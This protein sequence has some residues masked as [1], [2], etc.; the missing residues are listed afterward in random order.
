MFSKGLLLILLFS[1]AVLLLGD[2]FLRLIGWER[3]CSSAYAWGVAVL[4]A[5][6]QLVA[7]PLYRLSTSFTLFFILYSA[8]LA[9][10]LF[11]AVFSAVKARDWSCYAKDFHI[12]VRG[13]REAPL[14]T[15][16]LWG[17][18]IFFL[19]FSFGFYYPTTD[20]GY[21]MTRSM[22][23]IRQ[24]SM[25]INVRFAWLGW[26][27][28]E[29][30]DYT[31][32]STFAFLISYLS[33]LSGIQATILSK[34]FFAFCLLAAHIAAILTALEAI[35]E[36]KE[37]LFEKKTFGMLFYLIFLIFSVKQDSAGN[38]MT[39]YI[40]NGK[41]FLSAFILPML[42]ASCFMLMRRAD[43]LQG[44]EWLAV[45]T[46]LM[47]GIAVSIVG[48]NLP[49]ILYFTFGLAFLIATGFR[50]FSKIWKGALLSALPVMVYAILS[51]LFVITGQNDYFEAGTTTSVSWIGQFAEAVDFFQFVLYLFAC[52][53]VLIFGSRL[54]RALFVLAP[55]LLLIS[56]LNP[57]L[58]DPVCKYVTSSLVYW[59]LWWL[60][61]LYLLPAVVLTD[62]F[63]RLTKGNLQCGLLCALLSLGIVSG[64]EIFRYSITD[65]AETILPY[66]ENAGRLIHVRPELRSNLYGINPAT[67]LT[68]K[69]IEED[70]SGEDAPRMLMFFNRPFEIRQYNP[71]IVMA[72]AIRDIQLTDELIPGTEFTQRD[73]MNTYNEISDGVLLHKILRTL[74]VDY[75]CFEEAPAVSDM[76]ACGFHH[77]MN[78]AGIDLWRVL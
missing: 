47:A 30:P 48:L 50:S 19:I 12:T 58:T 5:V 31:D 51:Y 60:L 1:A 3:K 15:L 66:A 25:G 21:Y 64:F 18:L 38:W 8:V 23:V 63:D 11:W 54:Q 46:V 29:L 40:W 14:L 42:L 28:G 78:Y 74:D 49:I 7:Y 33:A 24:N 43:D 69:T 32:A 36:K 17:A 59:R 34:T 77:L 53:Y 10:L 16:I 61:P 70:W 75:I 6:V 27:N 67:Y 56:F 45:T 76:E 41:A 20:D 68:A 62:L 39:G 55:F 22:E 44:R 4:L 57:L 9:A 35:L 13:I 52:V 65:P 73:F 71:D 37:H 26:S 2:A 72:V